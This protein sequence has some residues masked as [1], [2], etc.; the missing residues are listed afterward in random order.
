M[1]KRTV[2]IY[3]EYDAS[4][5]TLCA[6]F[7]ARYISNCYRYA[8]WIVP[9]PPKSVKRSFGFSHQ[10]DT[11]VIPWREGG[12]KIKSTLKLCDTFFFFEPNREIL[13]MLPENA[14]T[15]Y[16]INPRNR[17]AENQAF[18]EQCTF[19][20]VTSPIWKKYFKSTNL[21]N[22]L[23]V[24]PFDPAV[25]C[26]P[27][28]DRDDVKSP[29]I[30]FPAFGLSVEERT[31]I[32]EVARQ[33]KSRCPNI[34]T[35]VTFYDAL[36]KPVPGIDSR[37][38]DWRL[39]RYLQNSDWLIDLNPRP[40][41]C[42]SAAFAGGYGIPWCGYDLAPNTDNLNGARRHLLQAPSDYSDCLDVRT[43]RP[44]LESTVEQIVSRLATPLHG[45]LE[46]HA[47]AGFWDHRRAEFFRVTNTVLGIKTRY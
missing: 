17:N 30:V 34:Q 6:V 15:A 4:E 37:T 42:L 2:G 25:Q 41:F 1:K 28:Q 31:F 9:Q 46:R 14:V 7:L 8:K 21:G 19:Q 20:L 35:V 47:G 39:I 27:K 12:K 13:E 18:A 45:D 23:L 22:H 3:A 5:Q 16:V 10:W 32:E 40:C 38:D 11:E 24:W 44:C 26:I 43:A 33:V 29:R 36:V